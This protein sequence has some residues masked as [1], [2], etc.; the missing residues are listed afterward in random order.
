MDLQNYRFFLLIK[1][2]EITDETKDKW[3]TYKKNKKIK[4]NYFIFN[5]LK[6]IMIHNFIRKYIFYN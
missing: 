2:S 1:N 4:K 3:N 5:I 6:I